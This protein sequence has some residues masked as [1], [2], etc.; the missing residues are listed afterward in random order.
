[1]ISSLRKIVDYEG[2][3]GV[4]LCISSLGLGFSLKDRDFL[5]LFL[6]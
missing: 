5:V 4:V 2:N 3:E 6:L 1:M